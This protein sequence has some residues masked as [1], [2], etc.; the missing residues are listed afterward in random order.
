MS[1]YID[2]E[3]GCDDDSSEEGSIDLTVDTPTRRKNKKGKE[4]AKPKAKPKRKRK[5]KDTRES[6]AVDWCFTTNNPTDGDTP[7]PVPAIRACVWQL[8]FGEEETPHFQGYILTL[9]S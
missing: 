3:A 4:K 1:Y 8:E 9:S 7:H 2:D 6:R 5:T